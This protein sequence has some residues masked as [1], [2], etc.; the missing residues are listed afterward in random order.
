MALIKCPD[1]G[2]KV[3]T[4]AVSCPHCGRPITE[5][6]IKD[7][8]VDSNNDCLND[9]NKEH[10]NNNEEYIKQDGQVYP[11]WIIEWKNKRKKVFVNLGIS[12]AIMF[13]I[14]MMT[15]G[16][17]DYNYFFLSVCIFSGT[18][19]F[20][21]GI[22]LLVCLIELKIRIRKFDD[23]YIVFYSGILKNYLIIE[24]E[25]QDVGGATTYSY[26]GTLPNKKPVNVHVNFWTGNV[27]IL[28]GDE[29]KR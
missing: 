15:I 24:N 22:L 2:G 11:E 19:V 14:T 23:Y 8:S 18:A 25:I 9:Q 7:N 13:A 16:L 27:K 20:F 6:D 3:S 29:I 21:V 10:I 1:C 4:L 17:T 12:A 26:Y 28:V 5:V